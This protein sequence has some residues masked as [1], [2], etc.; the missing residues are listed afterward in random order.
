MPVTRESARQPGTALTSRTTERSRSRSAMR[1][2][3]ARSGPTAR[4]GGDRQP[5]LRR[6]SRR[7]GSARPPSET[8]VRHSPG[9]AWRRIA[10][11]TDRLEDEDSEVMARMANRPAGGRGRP[12]SAPGHGT[13]RQA[14]SRSP[15]RTR[16]RPSEPKSGL[17]TTS[18][19][20]SSKAARAVG[21]RLAGPRGRDGQARPL[22][23][24]QRQILVDGRLDRTR[25]IEHGDPGRGQ[26]C[27]ASIRKTTC[28]RLPG[29]IIRTRTPSTCI[30]SSPPAP[31]ARTLSGDP[32]RG[33]DLGER[34]GVQ[35]HA[36][37][38]GRALKVGDVPAGS[39]NQG[40]QRLHRRHERPGQHAGLEPAEG[41]RPAGLDVLEDHLGR[42][43]EVRIDRVEVVVVPREDRGERIAVVARGRRRDP[44]ARSIRGW[45]RRR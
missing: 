10:P 3:P 29:G 35:D 40:G 18:P 43:E 36:Q 28:S 22:E 15:R 24:G 27:R 34:H 20:S 19:P 2:T 41:M 7:Q 33:R 8:F 4:G 44:G 39:G 37:P 11:R 12:R 23:Q 32:D 17:T 16:P 9:G 5:L 30:R 21:R 6:P 38:A 25:W 14:S 31:D 42:A 1:S 26:R 13:C 45:R